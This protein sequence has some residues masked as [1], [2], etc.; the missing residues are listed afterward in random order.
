MSAMQVCT[1]AVTVAIVGPEDYMRL[2]VDVV[3]NEKKKKLDFICR[4]PPFQGISFMDL[5]V[6]H[7]SLGQEMSCQC[8][9]L[10]ALTPLDN[11][12]LKWVN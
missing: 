12:L 11:T 9:H 4:L 6:G 2:L 1:T 10:R 3:E 5:L 8:H 7:T